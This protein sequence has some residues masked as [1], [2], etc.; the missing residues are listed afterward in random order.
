MTHLFT[1]R[2][3]SNREEDHNRFHRKQRKS[4][5]VYSG[6]KMRDVMYNGNN[7][8]EDESYSR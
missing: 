5:R 1:G 3:L 6:R 2:H 7:D 4:L 8:S